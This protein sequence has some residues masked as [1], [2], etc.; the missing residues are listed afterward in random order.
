MSQNEEEFQPLDTNADDVH[1]HADDVFTI[2][3]N[4]LATSNATQLHTTAVLGDDDGRDIIDVD[5]VVTDG[6][7]V[8]IHDK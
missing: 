4:N 5:N 6:L 1:E 3:S 7:V 8:S 2:D